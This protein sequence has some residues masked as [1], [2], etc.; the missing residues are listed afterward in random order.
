MVKSVLKKSLLFKSYSK[1]SEFPSKKF[2]IKMSVF[3]LQR[4][5]CYEFWAMCYEAF[6]K[7]YNRNPIISLRTKFTLKKVSDSTERE[8]NLT[9]KN[10]VLFY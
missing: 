10:L 2:L 7:C 5:V 6:F 3:V 9:V 4:Y 1:N 8:G